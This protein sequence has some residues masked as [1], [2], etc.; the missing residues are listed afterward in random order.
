MNRLNAPSESVRR[1]VAFT[2]NGAPV[3]AEVTAELSLLDLLRDRFDVISPKD[4]CQPQASCGCCTLL[5]EGKARLACTTKA[6]AVE[7]KHVT[8]LEGLSDDQRRLIAECFVTAGGVQCGFCIP[9]IA[10]RAYA[11]LEANPTPSREDILKALRGHLCRCTGYTKIIEAIE[12]LARVRQ[13]EP[14]P[15]AD[16]SGRVGTSLPRYAAGDAVLGQRRYVDDIKIDGMRYGALRLSDHPRARVTRIDTARAS[17]LPG[18]IAIVTA[19]EVPGQRWVGLIRRDWPVFVAVGEVTRYVGDVLA[20]VVAIDEATARQAAAMVDI[21]YEVL[22]PIT[23]PHRALE[24]DAPAIHPDGNLLSLSKIKRGDVDAAL[25]SAAFVIEDTYRTQ[26]IE[27]MYLEPEACIAIP[28]DNGLKILSQGQGVF[29]DRRQIAELLGW[30]AERIEVELISNGGAF[31]G[32]E[33]MSVQGQ[34]ALLAAAIGEPVKLRLNRKESFRVHVKRHALEMNY[35]VGC[36]ADGR[37]TVVRAR[38]IGDTGAYASV[39]AKVLERAAG[40]CCGPYRVEHLDV[41]ARAVYTNNV[42]CGAMRG[43]GVNQSAFAIEGILDRLAEK[44]GIDGWEMRWRN[45]IDHGDILATG[46]RMLKPFGL[47]KTLQA[48]KD[49]YYSARF[50]GIACGIKNVGI[51]NGMPDI[52]R[53]LLTIEDDGSVTIRTGFTEMGQGLFTICVQTACEETG[54]P[55]GLFHART[56]TRAELGVGQTTASRAT[57]LGAHAVI[58]ACRRFKE[59]LKPLAIPSA[60]TADQARAALKPLAGQTFFGEWICDDTTKLGADVPEPKLHM[61]YGFASQVVILDEHGGIEKVVACHDVGRV[62]NPTQLEGQIEGSIHMG[63]GYA[64]TEEFR[65]EGGYLVT[66]RI[67]DVGVLRAHQMPAIEVSF[68]EEPDPECPYGARGV[69]EIGLVPTAPAVAGAM[70]RYDGVVRRTLPMKDS[71]A[72]RALKHPSRRAGP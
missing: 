32:K 22:S 41:E 7:G 62:M 33:D 42:P 35:T 68:V 70:Y 72:A 8:T 59:I 1:A 3:R 2:L 29:D 10:M 4:G 30:D 65:Q 48:V 12:L 43:F 15:P 64:L 27:H 69:G 54:L 17:A 55:A 60:A 58:D 23:D 13:G 36:D 40:H 53:A 61:T 37:L 44:V 16:L 56:D 6:S 46:Q 25:A 14:L 67:K 26:P 20:A 63:L 57:V 34:T 52:G 66:E 51:G 28:N 49:A 9:G 50:S 45:A 38:I 39:G 47:K 71:P 31:G 11:L 5:I 24:P 19:K 21:D 18:V